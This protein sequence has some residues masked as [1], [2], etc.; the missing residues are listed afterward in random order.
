[1]KVNRREIRSRFNHSTFVNRQK[2]EKN[3]QIDD[4]CEEKLPRAGVRP[5]GGGANS[6]DGKSEAEQKRAAEIKRARHVQER[7]QQ[8]HGNERERIVQ[9]LQRGAIAFGID[10]G[11]QWEP[12]ARVIFTVHPRDCKEMRNLPQEQNGKQRP[13]AH[14]EGTAH[15]RPTDQNGNRAGKRANERGNV[16][17]FLERSI[18][19]QISAQSKNGEQTCKSI[20]EKE[21]I[22]CAGE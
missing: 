16:R 11:E 18:D 19:E 9:N 1:M 13:C 17:F 5:L 15:S 14:S 22:N 6:S 2:R 21:H 7:R 3:G 4:G 8:A 10:N 20:D 12:G